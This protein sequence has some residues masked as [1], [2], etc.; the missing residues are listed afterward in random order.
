MRVKR[1]GEPENIGK[2]EIDGLYYRT[3]FGQSDVKLQTN[4]FYTWELNYTVPKAILQFDESDNFDW[5]V[6]GPD[7]EFPI[8]E[9]EIAVRYPEGAVILDDKVFTGVYN[10]TTAVHLK[11]KQQMDRV[12][13]LQ[14]S[15]LEKR[16]R[17]L[18]D[19][20]LTGFDRASE[21]TP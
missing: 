13:L 12:T 7:W 15:G 19:A 17:D 8:R 9:W 21:V 11:E 20:L 2:T 6:I 10:T 3:Y 4:R 16:R 5:N 1:D 18:R 14:G